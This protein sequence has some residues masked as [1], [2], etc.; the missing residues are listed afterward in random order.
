MYSLTNLV[1]VDSSCNEGDLQP[2]FINDNIIQIC[3]EGMWSYICAKKGTNEWSENEAKVACYQMGMV[4]EEGSGIVVVITFIIKRLILFSDSE[5]AT[6]WTYS[7]TSYSKKN[8]YCL[9]L[10]E[11]LINCSADNHDYYCDNYTSRLYYYYSYATP[12]C[13][14]GIFYINNI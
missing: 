6:N 2:S 10:E 5:L 13:I 14:E 11:E 3:S 4:W 9:G 1:L 8:Y 7:N 12:K